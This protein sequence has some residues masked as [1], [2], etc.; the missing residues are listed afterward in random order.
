MGQLL[1]GSPAAAFEMEDRELAHLQVV[2]VNKFRRNETFAMSLDLTQD[3]AAGRESV[4]MHPSIQVRFRFDDQA[5]PAISR[6]WCEAL[7]TEA[8]SG[9]GLSLI[10]EPAAPAAPASA[11]A[12]ASA[13][14]TGAPTASHRRTAA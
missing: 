6:Q 9:R 10:P 1:Y 3:G 4:W 14:A 7:M 2:I 5:R 8:N 13:P 11:S 12:S